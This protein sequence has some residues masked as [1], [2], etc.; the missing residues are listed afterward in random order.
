[1]S[2]VPGAIIADYATTP[3]RFADRTGAPTVPSAEDFA[4]MVGGL[5]I[6]ESDYVIVVSSGRTWSDIAAA[7]DV[8]WTFRRM[9]HRRVSILD[10]GFL[11]YRLIADAPLDEGPARPRTRQ[12][13]IVYQNEDLAASR[14]RVLSAGRSITLI[15]AR[16]Q[17]DFLGINKPEWVA[18]YGTIPGAK[19]VPANWMTVDGRGQFRDLAEYTKLFEHLQIDHRDEMIVFGNGSQTGSLVWFVLYEILGNRRTRLYA[20]GMAEWAADRV[21]P[22]ERRVNLN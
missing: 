19:N 8:F 9:G 3:W 2:R 11:A 4:R 21:H 20:G 22:V 5:G 10:G 13:H 15:D 12:P 16:L 14:N 7:T 17:G 6:S 18:R 1:M